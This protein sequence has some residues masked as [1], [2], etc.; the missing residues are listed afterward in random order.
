ML[1]LIT[2]KLI[3]LIVISH[4]HSVSFHCFIP[5]H[6]MYT[7]SILY[8]Q[9]NLF[10]QSCSFYSFVLFLCA[11]QM[12]MSD[13][14]HSSEDSFTYI[15]TYDRTFIRSYLSI[16][17]VVSF[18]RNYFIPVLISRRILRR[19]LRTLLYRVSRKYNLRAFQY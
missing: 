9:Y 15:H 19:I 18:L 16:H 10:I 8:L 7:D 2:S 14:V 17:T 11:Y 12:R 13:S 6:Y 5:L 3:P 4:V 1:Q